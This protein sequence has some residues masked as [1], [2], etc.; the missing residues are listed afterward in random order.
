MRRTIG[1]NIGNEPRLGKLVE[2]NQLEA[3]RSPRACCRQLTREIAAGR[4]GLVTQVG[5]G[6]YVDPRQTGGKQNARTTEDLVEVVTLRGEEWLLFHASRSTSPSSAAP[7]PTRT[8][9]S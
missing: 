5:L 9:T 4:P 8:A 7:P 6:T 1:S 3:T 2:D